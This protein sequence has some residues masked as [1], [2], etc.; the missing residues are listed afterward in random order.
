MSIAQSIIDR[1]GEGRLSALAVFPLSATRIRRMYITDELREALNNP[2]SEDVERFARLEADLGT[3]VTSPTIDPKYLQLLLPVRN[4][5]W[6]IRSVRPRPS[7]RVVGL[8]ADKD[9]FVATQHYLRA[10]LGGFNTREWRDAIER[11]KATWTNLFPGYDP[12]YETDATKLITGAVS[13]Q[14]FRNN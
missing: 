3:F 9:L 4:G 11:A 7:I 8:F 12:N 10:P 14:Y 1:I 13:E 5:V 2:S 6:E